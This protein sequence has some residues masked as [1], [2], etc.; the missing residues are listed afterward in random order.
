MQTNSKLC[1]DKHS[2]RTE[3][4][5]VLLLLLIII[6]IILLLGLHFDIFVHLPLRSLMQHLSGMLLI[7]RQRFRQ[8]IT[9]CVHV[10]VNSPI[11]TTKRHPEDDQTALIVQQLARH[12][13]RAGQLH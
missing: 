5:I 8:I 2:P 13:L 7:R 3:M 10:T 1:Q 4:L 9:N 12:R 11:F 6:I